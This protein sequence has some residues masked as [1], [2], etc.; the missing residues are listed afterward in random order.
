MSAKQLYEVTM[1]GGVILLI[2]CSTTAAWM[3]S[4]ISGLLASAL[5][6]GVLSYCSYECLKDLAD[7]DETEPPA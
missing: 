1:L 5:W 3:I 7:E 2:A 4:P 6:G